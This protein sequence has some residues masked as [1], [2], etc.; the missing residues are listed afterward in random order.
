MFYVI[1]VLLLFYRAHPLYSH[2]SIFKLTHKC[3]F[4]KKLF[5]LEPQVYIAKLRYM[6]VPQHGYVYLHLKFYSSSIHSQVKALASTLTW[7]CIL[8]PLE[9]K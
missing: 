1:K 8:E 3:L 4:R 2:F 7:L 6:Q 5:I 9:C